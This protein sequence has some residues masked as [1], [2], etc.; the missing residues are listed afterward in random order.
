MKSVVIFEP[1]AGGHQMHHVSWIVKSAVEEANLNVHLITTARALEH[2][3]SSSIT[4]LDR[5]RFNIGIIEPNLSHLGYLKHLHPVLQQQFVQSQAL[6]VFLRNEFRH[7]QIATLFIPFFDAYALWPI[8]VKPRLFQDVDLSGIIHRAKHHFPR[9]GI[10]ANLKFHSKAERFAYQN[11]LRRSKPVQLFTV[12]PYLVRF[13]NTDRLKYLADPADFAPDRTRES[14][15]EELDIPSDRLLLFVFGYIDRRKAIR[16]L[17]DALAL[18]ECAEVSVLLG[19]QQSPDVQHLLKSSSSADLK[20]RGQLFEMPRF[21][22]EQEVDNAFNA[23]DIIWACYVNSDGNS[24]VLVK[25]GRAGRPAIVSQTGLTAKLVIDNEAGWLADPT[26]AHSVANALA[27]AR[28][29]TARRK[30]YAENLSDVFREHTRSNFVRPIIE[31]LA[32]VS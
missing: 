10:S 30:R 26:S 12:D 13:W 29:D 31:Y 17:L 24:G 7:K 3:S 1:D 14:L 11:I 2:P 18:D 25:A 6:S 16:T 15:R 28:R 27:D 19:G 4:K 20:R 8:V 23:A 32:R 22:N 9:M 21:L 5:K